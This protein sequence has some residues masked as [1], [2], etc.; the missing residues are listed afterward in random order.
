MKKLFFWIFLFLSFSNAANAGLWPFGKSEKPSVKLTKVNNISVTRGMKKLSLFKEFL[1]TRGKVEIKGKASGGKSGLKSVKISIN[2]KATW[3]ECSTSNKGAFKYEFSPNF[4]TP[5]VIYL[6]A[7]A[8]NGKTNNVIKSKFT[9]TFSE[10]S[11][12]KAV[13]ETLADMFKA[14]NEKKLRKFMKHVGRNFTSEKKILERALRKDF[15]VLSDIDMR[16]TINNIVLGKNGKVSVS[17]TYNRRLV[18][19]STGLSLTDNGNTHMVF[20]LS[21][22]NPMLYSMKQPLLFGLSEAST[23]VPGAVQGALASF[24][25]LDGS[26]ITISNSSVLTEIL[27]T[28]PNNF[29]GYIFNIKRTTI[30][31][32]PSVF[33]GDFVYLGDNIVMNT[34]GGVRDLG[35]KD[36]DDISEA[37]TS[38]YSSTIS[39]GLTGHTLALKLPSGKYALI[40]IL[41]DIVT[42]PLNTLTFKYKYNKS[43][44]RF[45]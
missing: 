40:E 20:D 34:G 15:S 22:G 30:E 11:S 29:T 32:N 42:I 37:P 31:T 10:K 14:Y 17:L 16:F 12:K 43:G 25:A 9:L 39:A 5:Y 27:P 44:D 23:L 38:G 7:L 13:K 8:N 1:D 35:V 2:G 3:E 24:F 45:F 26:N 41:S 6:E 33:Q 28:I 21:K 36:I 19:N 18:K 4:D